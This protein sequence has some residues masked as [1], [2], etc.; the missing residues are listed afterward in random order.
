[1]AQAPT[2][3]LSLPRSKLRDLT[4]ECHEIT[5]LL[6]RV[7]LDRARL[8]TSSELL[9]EKMISLGKLSAGLAHE[10]NNPASAI[11]RSSAQLEDHLDAAEEAALALAAARLSNA[12]LEAVSA[13]RVSCAAEQASG[14][15]SPMDQA[16][17]EDAIVEWL[18]AHALDTGVAYALA[19]TH[20]TLEALNQLA[21]VV[22]GP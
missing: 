15:L 18:C 17:R 10:L 2:E 5:S 21:A 12:E 14:V 19:D 9:N 11:E 3:I 7:M 6:V 13:I 8:F 20:V 1:M 16:V 4:H 22:S